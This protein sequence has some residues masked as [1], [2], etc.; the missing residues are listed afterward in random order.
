MAEHENNLQKRLTDAAKA[1]NPQ[2]QLF[3]REY[4]IDFNGTKAAVRAGYS[5]KTAASTA[6]RLLRDPKIIAFRDLLMEERFQAIGIDKFNIAAEVWGIYR[7]CSQKEPVLEWDSVQR[8]WVESG[9]WQFNANGA[10]KAL[11]MLMNMLPSIK[12]PADE[13]ENYEDMLAGGVTDRQF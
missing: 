11:N 1:L 12:D 5:E 6:S 13:G 7:K 10:L 4:V 2:Q 3:T 8:E 9:E